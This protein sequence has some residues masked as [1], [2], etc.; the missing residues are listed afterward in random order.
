MTKKEIKKLVL[1]SYTK[2][3]LDGKKVNKIVKFFTKSDLKKYIKYLKLNEKSKNIIVEVSN[4]SEKNKILKEVKMM[5][6]NKNISIKE[7]KN[8]IAG[9]KIINNDIIYEANLKN[10]LENLVAFMN[11]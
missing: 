7:N 4:L 8:I 2:D 11:Y 3:K 6:P 1:A 10:N 5:Y 9:I